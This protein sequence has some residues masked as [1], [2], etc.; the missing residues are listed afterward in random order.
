M[1]INLKRF[2]ILAGL[3]VCSI[4]LAYLGYLRN[5]D[6][7]VGT[8][9]EF[10]QPAGPAIMN[11]SEVLYNN[12]NSDARFTKLRDDIAY[13]GRST[14]NTY[15]TGEVIDIVFVVTASKVENDVITF[16]GYYEENKDNIIASVTIKNFDQIYTTLTNSV[17]DANIDSE[18]P[19]NTT[20]NQFVGSL[21]I[22]KD[23]YNITYD[24]A[25]G[26]IIVTLYTRDTKLADAADTDIINALGVTSLD[27]IAVEYIFP[28][29]SPIN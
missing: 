21:P 12:I 6:R 25:T 14:I 8:S 13:F 7:G 4:F 29:L 28:A 3:V 23:Y 20:F 10:S 19:S 1:D 22:T 16:E 18:L 5:S 2:L 27:A 17:N 15:R 9:V 11:N 24:P 26:S